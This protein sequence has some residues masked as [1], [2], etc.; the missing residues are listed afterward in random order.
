M[1]SAFTKV[2]RLPAL[3]NKEST[4]RRYY[5][6]PVLKWAERN[7]KI[8]QLSLQ[9]PGWKLTKYDTIDPFLISVEEYLSFRKW[10]LPSNGREKAIA[11]TSHIL[12]PP[13]TIAL[14]FR[15]A[16]ADQGKRNSP[17]RLC[18]VGARAEATLP[19]EYWKEFLLV[20]SLATKNS[21]VEVQLEFVGPDIHLNTPDTTVSWN[22]SNIITLQWSHKGLL[23]DLHEVSWDAYVLMN[24]G[25][26]HNNLI[27]NWKPT[28]HRLL[29]ANKPI[30]L[31]AHSEIDAQRDAALLR[32]VYRIDVNYELNPFSSFIRYEDPF[33]K[34]HYV[35][36]N[37][38]MAIIGSKMI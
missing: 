16:L 4:C 24:P 21:E 14:F 22:T 37:R 13:L 5:R 29:Q 25:L 20:S 9:P 31:T 32:E 18:C 12:S 33:D 11:L 2:K 8:A 6:D 23:H 1:R 15:S 19:Y 30:L 26:G 34:N 27:E 17:L 3:K 36:P 38:F 35:S 10:V 28:L 7:P